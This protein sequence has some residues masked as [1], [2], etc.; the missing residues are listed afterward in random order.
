MS[1]KPAL[2]PHGDQRGGSPGM[3]FDSL[4]HGLFA[5]VAVFAPQALFLTASNFVDRRKPASRS[6]GHFGGESMK[7]EAATKMLR[8]IGDSKT[9]VLNLHGA[10][11]NRTGKTGA[12]TM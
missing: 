12:A 10:A 11:P 9:F 1:R 7:F 3:V 6:S 4:T 2:E 5:E 8:V